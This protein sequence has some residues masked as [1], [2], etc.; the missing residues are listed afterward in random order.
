MINSIKLLRSNHEEV[1]PMLFGEFYITKFRKNA[2]TG[3]ISNLP[4]GRFESP[5]ATHV[6]LCW[7]IRIDNILNCFCRSPLDFWTWIIQ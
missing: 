1:D 5:T 4:D 7:I 2:A 6:Q 3:R